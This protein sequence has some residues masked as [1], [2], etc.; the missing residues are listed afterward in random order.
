MVHDD[1]E[2]FLLA[3]ARSISTPSPDP[4]KSRLSVLDFQT[5]VTPSRG[6]RMASLLRILVMPLND[7]DV[8]GWTPP[9]AISVKPVTRR[10]QPLCL[11]PFRTSFREYRETNPPRG[12]ISKNKVC[13]FARHELDLAQFPRTGPKSSRR[14]E[15]SHSWGRSDDLR[16][17]SYMPTVMTIWFAI[18]P[19]SP[20]WV[21]TFKEPGQNACRP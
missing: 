10:K 8:G 6:K 14:P 3:S 12:G 21:Q 15:V 20:V 11:I 19:T 16:D 5:R 9:I 1:L 2:Q 13:G 18:S 7:R 17:G 4:G